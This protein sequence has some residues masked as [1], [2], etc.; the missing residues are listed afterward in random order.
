EACEDAVNSWMK[1][2]SSTIIIVNGEE[3]LAPL[4]LH[5]LS[6]VGA[7]VLYGQP[8]KGVVVRVCG[9]ESKGRCRHLLELFTT[10]Y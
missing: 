3:D 4:L 1:D 8:G 6:P 10:E 9:E 7:V 5:P 2:R